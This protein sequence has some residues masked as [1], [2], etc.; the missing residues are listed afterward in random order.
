MKS[1]LEMAKQIST[2]SFIMMLCCLS[3]LPMAICATF[4]GFY[5]S[6]FF[7]TVKV[8]DANPQQENFFDVCGIKGIDNKGNQVIGHTHWSIMFLLNAI[9]YTMLILLNI[10]LIF[11]V[12]CVSVAFCS[13]L[14]FCCSQT[15][16]LAFIVTTGIVIHVGDGEECAK[17][18]TPIPELDGR[19]MEDIGKT[20]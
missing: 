5:W 15:A 3:I 19:T 10:C 14:C 1:R 13:T 2:C 18:S 7:D 8:N 6:L 16:L 20:V 11:S 17:N 4:S 9:V 12:K